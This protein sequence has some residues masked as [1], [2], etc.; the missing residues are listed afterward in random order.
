[1][2][3]DSTRHCGCAILLLHASVSRGGCVDNSHAHTRTHF[4][5]SHTPIHTSWQ[6]NLEPPHPNTHTLSSQYTHI[7]QP[8]NHIIITEKLGSDRPAEAHECRGV[9]ARD[10]GAGGAGGGGRR[11]VLPSF[12]SVY[13]CVCGWRGRYTSVCLY[14]CAFLYVGCVDMMHAAAGGAGEVVE[15]LCLCLFFFLDSIAWMNVCCLEQRRDG[16]A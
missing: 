8:P 10:E 16:G 3:S 2:G 6:R 12:V 13:P 14:L 15:A 7:I 5:L 4:H 1:M 11:C 9:A